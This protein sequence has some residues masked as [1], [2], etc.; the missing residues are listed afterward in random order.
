MMT[1]GI[2]LNFDNGFSVIELKENVNVDPSNNKPNQNR[3]SWKEELDYSGA[4]IK[5]RIWKDI[6]YYPN[7]PI[8]HQEMKET[9]E[10]IDCLHE[11][12]V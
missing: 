10:F 12:G 7:C 1:L 2:L 6:E 5:M 3:N 11:F 4:N 9:L 8:F